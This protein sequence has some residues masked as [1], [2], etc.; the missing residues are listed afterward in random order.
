RGTVKLE[1]SVP[2][3]VAVP[4]AAPLLEPRYWKPTALPFWSSWSRDMDCLP[5][6]APMGLAD[7]LTVQPAVSLGSLAGE[8]ARVTLAVTLRDRQDAARAHAAAWSDALS[9]ASDLVRLSRVARVTRER[10]RLGLVDGDALARAEADLSAARHRAR[11]MAAL[12]PY[13]AP[14]LDCVLDSSR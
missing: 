4:L 6:P 7:R 1:I 12:L 10:A 11:A 8:A 3:H 2:L 9:V 13:T 14:Y 5:P